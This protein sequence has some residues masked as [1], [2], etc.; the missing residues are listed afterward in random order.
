[1]GKSENTGIMNNS[2]NSA[3]VNSKPM[4][5]RHAVVWPYI[6]PRF[7]SSPLRPVLIIA[8]SVFVYE[9]L[10]VYFIAPLLLPI[11]WLGIYDDAVVM[12]LVLCPLLYFFLYRPLA[13]N[14]KKRELTEESLR[15]SELRLRT[16]F[17]TSPDAITVSS[18]EDGRIFTFNEGLTTLSGFTAEDVIGKSACDAKLWNDPK[19][20]EEMIAELKKNGLVNNFES[21]FKR[22]DGRVITGLT[23]ARVIEIDNEPRLLAVTR[24]ITEL[25]KA[26]RKLNASNEFLQIA[27]R[28]KEMA[29]LLNDF[30]AE[31]KRLTDCFAVGIR[32]LDEQGNLPF[33]AVVGCGERFC[34]SDNPFP[35][36][37][38]NC[39]CK[40]IV[41]QTSGQKSPFFTESGSFYADSTSHL[42]AT[43]SEKEK[44][45]M[46]YMYKNPEYESLAL[47]PIR[48]EGK[49]HG[50]I[51]AADPRQ[52][53]IAPETVEILEGA[54]MQLG[55]AIE[56]VRAEEAVQK[57]HRELEKRVKDRTAKLV[58][59]NK[60]LNLEI[61]ERILNEKKLREQQDK[62]R[63]LSSELLLTE[64]RERRRIATELHD[65]IGQ[66][67]AITKIKLGELRED[68][69]SKS[70]VEALDKIR[71]FIDQIIQDTRT[72]TFELSPPVLYE[73]GLEA[74]LEWLISQIQEKH[75]IRI[76]FKNGDQSAL[77]DDSCHVVV[78]QAT[79][80]LLFNI[81]KHARARSAVVS[82]QKDEET[83]RLDISDDGVGFD[84]AKLSSSG[85]GSMGFGLFSIRER[86]SSLGGHIEIESE[87]GSGTRVTMVLPLNCQI[88]TKGN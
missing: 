26:S 36:N 71:Q 33:K 80:E 66:S 51:F 38:G 74:G 17:Q 31:T 12:M 5:D 57:S 61:E 4:A 30:I 15:V 82:I 76:M 70:T 63:S 68:L 47:I 53:L 29:P 3:S 55:T 83:I 56:R 11:G 67:L 62:L 49:I 45:K 9:I 25:K 2:K 40:E 87:P 13:A 86:L 34:K 7:L 16:V 59:A 88:K 64:E 39:M 21:K 42:L 85:A 54:S 44:Q 14:I 22:K 18:L 32:I 43:V 84:T 79:R 20:R 52:N 46:C 58:S 41:R 73:L 19:N 72:L 1:M 69:P 8:L 78:F 27:N 48:A 37:A 23:S 28:H 10:E 81:V 35:V 50:L 60:L 24:D 6:S 77:F 65:R 75:R